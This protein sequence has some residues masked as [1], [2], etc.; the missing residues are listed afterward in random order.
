[1]SYLLS[2]AT[3][4]SRNHQGR[5]GLSHTNP[6]LFPHS[7][8]SPTQIGT[9]ILSFSLEGI[10]G[11]CS[12]P[13]AGCAAS[14]LHNMRGWGIVATHNNVVHGMSVGCVH[15]CAEE[16]PSVPGYTRTASSCP[17]TASNSHSNLPYMCGF[18][19]SFVYTNTVIHT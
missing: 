19:C 11:A 13:S 1:M 18:A 8:V 10:E 2:P 6:V 15:V 14:K 16:C 4:T 9:A 12:N 17:T 5:G 7:I 3:F